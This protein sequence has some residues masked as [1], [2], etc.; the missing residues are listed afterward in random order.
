MRIQ[1][2]ELYFANGESST[3]TLRCFKTRHKLHDDPCT[4][5]TITRLVAR[6]R[7]TGSVMDKPK[8]GRSSLEEEREPIV[9]AEL[10][11]QQSAHSLGVASSSAVARASGI[12]QSSVQRILR[13]RLGLYPY[14]LQVN[15]KLSDTDHEKR[16]VFARL[17]LSNNIDLENVLWTD[18]SYFSLAGHVV[19]HN[20]II[21]GSEKPRQTCDSDMHAPKVCVWFGYS[22][23]HRLQPFF[24]PATIN[25][26]NYTEMLRS[27]VMPQLR[28]KR[29]LTRTVWQ[30]DGAPPH[31]S[32]VA[33]NFLSSIFPDDRIIA[34]GY[35][36]NWPAH[37]PDLS[38]LDYYFWSV[39]KDRVYFNFV[40]RNLQELQQ[41]IIDVIAVMDQDEL[42]RSVLHLPTRLEYVLDNNGRT[43]EHLL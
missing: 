12:P 1:L 31:F 37:S 21:W 27:H 16:V 33:R 28:R 5:S 23:R 8:S 7:E 39:V 17:M 11:R 3:A 15:Q 42:K 36:Q 6:F 13:H 24:F 10:E 19:R 4:V 9:V 40:P 38:P 41:R 32:L 22:A 14:R 34:R 30:Q 29:I 43:F 18:E 35:R 2:L 25:G 20:S 26:E